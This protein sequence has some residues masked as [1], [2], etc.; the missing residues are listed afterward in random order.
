MVIDAQC[1]EFR[2]KGFEPVVVVGCKEY[3]LKEYEALSS[4]IDASEVGRTSL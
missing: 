1:V 4:H 3:K 2:E